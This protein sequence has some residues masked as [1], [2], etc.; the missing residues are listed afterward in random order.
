[1]MIKNEE[2]VQDKESFI[3]PIK[4]LRQTSTEER[5]AWSEVHS[6]LLNYI[7]NFGPIEIQDKRQ[8]FILDYDFYCLECGKIF[9]NRG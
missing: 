4:E 3:S 7:L 8:K 2:R 9:D 5:Q 1:M 6:A